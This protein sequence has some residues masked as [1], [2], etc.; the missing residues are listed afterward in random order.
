M[1]IVHILFLIRKKVFNLSSEVSCAILMYENESFIKL[2]SQ[3][4]LRRSWKGDKRFYFK[5]QMFCL[6]YM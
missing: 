2:S 4:T 1:K 6:G 3:C 5:K